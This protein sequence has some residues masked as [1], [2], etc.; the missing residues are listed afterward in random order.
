MAGGVVDHVELGVGGQE[1]AL[2]AGEVVERVVAEAADER[3]DGLQVVQRRLGELLVDLDVARE[4]VGQLGDADVVQADE[5]RRLAEGA[6]GEEQFDRDGQLAVRGV[7][8]RGDHDVGAV[9]ARHPAQRLAAIRTR[10]RVDGP[11][12]VGSAQLDRRDLV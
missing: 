1:A 12:L 6:V 10:P 7:Q 9:L 11:D 4:H 5:L 2:G 3:H 8:A